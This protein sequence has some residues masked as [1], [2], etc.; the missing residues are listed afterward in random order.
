[1]I[2][3]SKDFVLLLVKYWNWIKIYERD[4]NV[5]KLKKKSFIY[6]RFLLFKFSFSF[7][8]LTSTKVQKSIKY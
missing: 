5:E 1:M 2:I 8:F 4:V 7:T 3:V 6:F